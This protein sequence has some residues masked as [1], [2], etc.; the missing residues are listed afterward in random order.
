MDLT[1]VI[2]GPITTE[3]S[4]RL[5]AERTYM[6]RVHPKATKIDVKAA[7]KKYWDCEVTSV[8]VQRVRPK[9]R[10]VGRGNILE[11]RHPYKRAI[12]TLHTDSKPLDLA[13][14]RT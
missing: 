6:V 8:R 10:V 9:M 3:K 1:A 14:F 5:K 12:V 11:K 7:L 13:A 4:E 2:L